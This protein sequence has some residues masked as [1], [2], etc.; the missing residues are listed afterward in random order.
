MTVRAVVADDEPIMRRN[1]LRLLKPHPEIRVQAECGDGRSA[2]EAILKYAPDVV[3]L[4]IEM[5]GAD[6]LRVVSEI[7]RERMPL[8]VFITAHAQYAIQA[9]EDRAVDYLLK[10]F[11]Q[12]RFNETLSRLSQRLSATSQRASQAIPARSAYLERIP[13]SH[14]GHVYPL[15]TE[16][17]DWMQAEKNHVLLHIGD[18]VQVVRRTLQS[19]AEVLDPARFVR[20]HRST[21][22]NVAKIREIQ[23][24][25]NGFHMAI[26]TKVRGSFWA[27][28][29]PIPRNSPLRYAL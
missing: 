17:V 29:G 18:Q 14:K 23:P 10:P 20:I 13:I 26:S 28:A 24:W 16:E 9:F 27:R 5:P 22:V 2:I 7:G 8:T 15:K 21:I 12:V 4:D 3:F 1:I 11:G 6:G 19:L 25:Q